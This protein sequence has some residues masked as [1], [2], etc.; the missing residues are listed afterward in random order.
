M[1]GFSSQELV[2]VQTARPNVLLI[3]GDTEVEAG[4]R[5]LAP[6]VRQPTV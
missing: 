3:G 5:L 4:L 2:I 1:L 6:I